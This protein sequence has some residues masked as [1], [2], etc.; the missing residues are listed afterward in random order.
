MSVTGHGT[1]AALHPFTVSASRLFAAPGFQHWAS[2]LAGHSSSFYP[3]FKSHPDYQGSGNDTTKQ[4]P[5]VRPAE[6]FEEV[7]KHSS[8][9]GIKVSLTFPVPSPPPAQGGGSLKFPPLTEGNS[10]Q[11]NPTVLDSLPQISLS[12]EN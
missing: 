5:G 11:R 10:S 6:S 4:G 2:F 12:L 3:G 1:P 9:L 7:V 8:C